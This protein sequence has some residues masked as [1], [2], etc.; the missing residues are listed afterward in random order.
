MDMKGH[1]TGIL[2]KFHVNDAEIKPSKKKSLMAGVNSL[3]MVF[4]Y[5]VYLS[6]SGIYGPEL[7]KSICIHIFGYAAVGNILCSFLKLNPSTQ[8]FLCSVLF[9]ISSGVSLI[10]QGEGSKYLGHD[11]IILLTYGVAGISIGAVMNTVPCY[12]SM[13]SPSKF[14]PSLL[15]C[16]G[17]VGIVGGLIFG[18]TLQYFER[19]IFLF[20]MVIFCISIVESLLFLYFRRYAQKHRQTVRNKFFNLESWR[21]ILENGKLSIVL[22]VA[23][24]F[25]QHISGVNYL[26]FHFTNIFGVQGKIYNFNMLYFWG[27]FVTL[28]GGYTQVIG[29]KKLILFSALICILANIS[30]Y[31]EINNAITSYFFIFGFNMGLGNIPFVLIGD[32]FPIEVIQ[33]GALIGTSANW[34]GGILSSLVPIEETSRGNVAFLWYIGSLMVFVCLFSAFFSETKDKKADY[35]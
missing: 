25:A 10:F 18:N 34:I 15:G 27:M 9:S 17:G 28:L 5:G 23:A 26:I 2:G 4:L 1:L 13:V 32:I 20:N 29:R 22:M 8:L 3:V 7:I 16:I 6:T 14:V 19:D 33:E 12:I 35:Q 24:H 21:S 30:Y 11:K 31:Y